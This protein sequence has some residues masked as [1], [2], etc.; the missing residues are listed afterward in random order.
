MYNVSRV[1]CLSCSL[2]GFAWYDAEVLVVS[3]LVDE[4]DV[5]PLLELE[6]FGVGPPSTRGAD[7]S[8]KDGRGSSPSMLSFSN[9]IRGSTDFAFHRDSSHDQ[10][11]ARAIPTP[12]IAHPT[13]TPLLTYPSPAH[14]ASM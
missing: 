5:N 1:V 13:S 3:V 9:R 10:I 11:N 7:L 2:F 8:V 12:R 4:V 14:I 6:T